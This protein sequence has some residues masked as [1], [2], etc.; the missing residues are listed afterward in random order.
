MQFASR[1]RWFLFSLNFDSFCRVRFLPITGSTFSCHACRTP[2][3]GCWL[4]LYPSYYRRGRYLLLCPY[5]GFLL[6][7]VCWLAFLSGVL[8]VSAC[9]GAITY[10]SFSVL[11]LYVSSTH[12]GNYYISLCLSC[13]RPWPSCV[14]GLCVWS[15]SSTAACCH[16]FILGFYVSLVIC[17]LTVLGSGIP[18]H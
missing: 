11:L 14:S 1:H 12:P 7:R 15:L 4:V 10:L 17:L 3:K 5:S 16:S 18:S 8:L 2:T 9:F 6:F 13:I